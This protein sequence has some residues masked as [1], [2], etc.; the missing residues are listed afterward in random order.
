[1]GVRYL[2]DTNAVS[3]LA[4][5]EGRV[6]ERLMQ[7]QRFEVTMSSITVAELRFGAE[8]KKSAKLHRAIDTLV[9][10][11]GVAPFDVAAAD[12]FARIA[13]RLRAKA[14]PS[15]PWMRCWQDTRSASAA[16]S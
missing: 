12:E 7:R 10:E 13:S 6:A 3:C 2:L 15:R 11:L 1:M 9:A 4:R 5:R 8:L 14:S 16:S